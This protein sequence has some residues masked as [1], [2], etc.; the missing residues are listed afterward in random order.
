[1]SVGD[2]PASRQIETTA[3]WKAGFVS[4]GSIDQSLGRQALERDRRIHGE[5]VGD[6]QRRNGAL[7]TDGRGAQAARRRG[8]PHDR[9]I[10]PLRAD[11]LDQAER[12]PGL[13]RDL[14]TRGA[15]HEL[16]H[17][18]GHGARQGVRHVADPQARGGL[19]TSVACGRL[20]HVGLVQHAPRLLEHRVTGIGE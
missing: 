20:G 9:G 8:K 5:R 15:R 7:V 1:M 14:H 18:A 10:E 19:V 11:L 4:R 6:R 2:S 16:L 13:E 17:R 3:L 12:R